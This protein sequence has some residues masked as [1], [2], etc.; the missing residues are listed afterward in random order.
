[1]RRF[2]LPD[3]L[4]FHLKSFKIEYSVYFI[5]L[6][7]FELPLIELSQGWQFSRNPLD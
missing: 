2:V 5:E 3:D 6:L 7:A 1:M 4:H